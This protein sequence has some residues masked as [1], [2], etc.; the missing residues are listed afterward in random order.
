MFAPMANDVAFGSD[1][2]CVNDVTPDGVVGKHHIIATI[3]SNII[4]SVANNIT[5]AIAKTSLTEKERTLR[6]KP[7]CSLFLFV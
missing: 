4:M 1:V 2:H 6:I 7:F 3:G 5:F